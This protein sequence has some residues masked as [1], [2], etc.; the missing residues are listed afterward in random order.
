MEE[1]L[2]AVER[3]VAD[4]DGDVA[5]ALGAPTGELQSRIDD[6]ESTT[7]ELESG[8][9][10]V[11][12]YVGQVKSVDD[13]I[14]QR[15]DAAAAAVDDVEDRVAALERR[16]DGED[17]ESSGSESVPDPDGRRRDESR[18]KRSHD[19]AGFAAHGDR[20]SRD[21]NQASHRKPEQRATHR[22][23]DEPASQGTTTEARRRP[24]EAASRTH[25]THRQTEVGIRDHNSGCPHCGAVAREIDADSADG[26]GDPVDDVDE[27]SVVARLRDAL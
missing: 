24:A 27:Q 6:L 4:G 10:A 9:Q 11:R 2:R 23:L 8:L 20:L 22:R 19:R 17:A 18:P 12:G 21:G 25:R 13:E 3:A 5:A 7:T 14:E 1:R 15:A 26:D 16:L